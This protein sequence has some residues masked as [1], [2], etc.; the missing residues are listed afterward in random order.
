[1]M[2][3]LRLD[4]VDLRLDE[5]SAL[6]GQSLKNMQV[7][8]LHGQ[9][10][11]LSANRDDLIDVGGKTRDVMENSLRTRAMEF[12]VHSWCLPPS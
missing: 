8:P 7:S 11:V 6:F 2:V 3:C 12:K 9:T 4:M 10:T 1:M 5:G